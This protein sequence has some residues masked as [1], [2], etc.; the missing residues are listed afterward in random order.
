MKFEEIMNRVTGFSIPVFGISW[1]PPEL[2]RS[3]AKRV[4]THLEDR[5]V[6]YNPSQMEMPD[7]CA[8]SVIEIRQMLSNEIA[9]LSED[10][11]L[12]KSFRAMRAACRKFLDTVGADENIVRFG[13]DRGHYAS[14]IFNGAIGELR[15]VFGVHLAQI[16]VRY[17]LDIEDDLASILPVKDEADATIKDARSQRQNPARKKR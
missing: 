7:H 16:A 8:S 1:N 10:S 6:L 9:G 15:G 12:G 13:A 14:W 17:G 2:D 3:I 5:R 4:I 11:E